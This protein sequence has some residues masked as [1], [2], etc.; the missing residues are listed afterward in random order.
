MAN[1]EEKWI[2][3]KRKNDECNDDLILINELNNKRL[4]LESNEIV[5]PVTKLIFK[6]PYSANDG[7]TYEKW[8]LDNLSRNSS[9]PQSPLTREI[10]TKYVENKFVLK[11]V[12]NFLLK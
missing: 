9:N 8:T 7:F 2:Q 12:N 11:A 10:I 4:C 5:C 3:K 1:S 6:K